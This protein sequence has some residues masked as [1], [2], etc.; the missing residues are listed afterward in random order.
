MAKTLEELAKEIYNECL[1]D[2]EE[3]TEEEALEMA[4]M[5]MK[6]KDLKRY[7]KDITKQKK[8]VVRERKVDEEKGYILTNVKTLLEEMNA[9]IENI[10]TETEIKFNYN[11]NSYTI[12]L[13]KHRPKK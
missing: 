8:K 3:V 1:E 5:E 2:G 12:K 9:T 13:T 10:K 4:K 7:E 11:N 6:S